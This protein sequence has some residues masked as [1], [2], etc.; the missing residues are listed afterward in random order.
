LATVQQLCKQYDIS[1]QQHREPWLNWR[2]SKGARRSLGWIAFNQQAIQFRNGGFAF[3]GE[4]YDVFL[5]RPLPDNAR[6]GCGSFCED[7]RGRWYINVPV[8]VAEAVQAVNARVSIDLGL[9]TLATLSCSDKIPMPAFYRAHEAKLGIDGARLGFAPSPSAMLSHQTNADQSL[10]RPIEFRFRHDCF[11]A[12]DPL[13]CNNWHC[14]DDHRFKMRWAVR[15]GAL[16]G[17]T[18][19]KPGSSRS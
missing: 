18:V 2:K 14:A 8:E 6:I 12:P 5:R 11:I 4:I 13:R 17:L 9:K 7:S 3:R 19:A 10:F 15:R 16:K 1:R